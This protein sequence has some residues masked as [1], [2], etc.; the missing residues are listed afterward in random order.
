M[1]EPSPA[2]AAAAAARNH[3]S[4]QPSQTAAASHQGIEGWLLSIA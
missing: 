1:S 4:L 2:H 3:G